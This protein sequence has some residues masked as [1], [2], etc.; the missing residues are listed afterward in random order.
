MA[1]VEAAYAIAA[2]TAVLLICLG[3][4]TA[5]VSAVRCTDAARE[6]ARLTA[7]GDDRAQ[8]VGR[9]AAPGGARIT[10]TRSDAEVV[11]VV[12]AGA[13]LLPMLTVSGRAVALME[14]DGEDDDAPT[15]P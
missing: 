14:P 5:M 12:E 9:S 13:P 1:T 4:L 15:A 2:I 6:V 8:A 10:V 11:V 3:A 7:A